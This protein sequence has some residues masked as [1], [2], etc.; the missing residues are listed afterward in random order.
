MRYGDGIVHSWETFADPVAVEII[1]GAHRQD[2]DACAKALL[3]LL[4]DM[5][6]IGDDAQ[7]AELHIFRGEKA[8]E[9]FLTVR[10]LDEPA[11]FMTGPRPW[12]KPVVPIPHE[13]IV[14]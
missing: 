10:S 12:L 7:V 11:L 13:G 1:S 4:V 3:D 9:T 2:I 6:V 8:R 14:T 5:G